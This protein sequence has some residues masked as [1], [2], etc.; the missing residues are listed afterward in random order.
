MMAVMSNLQSWKGGS[1]TQAADATAEKSRMALPSGLVHSEEVHHQ[2]YCIGDHNAHEDRN[3]LE[4]AFSPDVENDD[5]SKSNQ[6]NE[7]VGGRIGDC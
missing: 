2:S 4:H 7:P 1:P 3:D 6:G 5:C